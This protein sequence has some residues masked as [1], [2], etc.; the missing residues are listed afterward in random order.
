M[1]LASW[2]KMP[3]LWRR[4]TA[5]CNLTAPRTRA[6]SEGWYEPTPGAAVLATWEP[7]RAKRSVDEANDALSPA[8]G[9]SGAVAVPW[10][11][12]TPGAAVFTTCEPGRAKRSVVEAK[13]ALGLERY[14]SNGDG[15]LDLSEFSELVAEVLAEVLVVDP[16]NVDAAK[17]GE[18]AA[19]VEAMAEAVAK[20]EAH[21]LVESAR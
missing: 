8:L 10:Y 7:G 3:R 15:R 4:R 11:E 18:E 2:R 12:P 21:N 5:A 20:A 19:M 1:P 17:R 14:D 16:D 13:E 9:G 6:S